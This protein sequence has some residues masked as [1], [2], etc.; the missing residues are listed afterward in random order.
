M[1]DDGSLDKT[2]DVVHQFLKAEAPV[3]LVEHEFNKGYGAAL[4]SGFEAATGDYIFFTDSDLR[5]ELNELMSLWTY[6][7]SAE[8]VSGY[9][10]NRQDPSHRRFNAWAWGRL[11]RSLTGIKVK[12]INC[13]FK[14]FK[15]KLLSH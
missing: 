14:Y 6:R 13:A 15:E 4:R 3:R 5:F 7:G 9:R 10:K 12:D 1:V 2:T 8:I 11:V